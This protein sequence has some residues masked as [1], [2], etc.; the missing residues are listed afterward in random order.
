MIKTSGYRVSPT[1][2][3][4]VLIEIPGVSNAVVF[5]KEMENAE[6]IIV[7]VLETN[8]LSDNEKMVIQEC[9]K[10]LPGYMVPQEMH[11]EKAFRKTAN[12]KIDRSYIKQKYSLSQ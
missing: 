7:A 1:E 11:L 6:Q 2:V 5:G 8:N 10:R 3:E 4:E 12:G 9:R